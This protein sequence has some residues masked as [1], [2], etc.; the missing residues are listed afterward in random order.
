MDRNTR[1]RLIHYGVVHLRAIVLRLYTP[2]KLGGRGLIG[3]E[4]CVASKLRTLDLYVASSEEKLLKFIATTNNLEEE[5]VEGKEEC[6]RRIDVEKKT[7]R[8][9]MPLRL[10][11]ILKP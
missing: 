1:Q 2:P 6:R 4:E 10:K 7:L 8:E 3:V 11:G 5:N 9:A